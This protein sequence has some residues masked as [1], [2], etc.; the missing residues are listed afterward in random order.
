MMEIRM[1]QKM[2]GTPEGRRL[3]ETLKRLV[4][5]EGLSIEEVVSQSAEHLERM[6]RIARAAG[7]TVKQVADGSLDLYEAQ[8]VVDGKMK[9]PVR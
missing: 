9:A 1:A 4:K 6:E 2:I 8:L 7:L 3:V 5:N